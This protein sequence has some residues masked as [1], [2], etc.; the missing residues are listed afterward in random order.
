PAIVR[1]EAL[2]PVTMWAPRRRAG[3]SSP[4]SGSSVDGGEQDADP[5]EESTEEPVD[6]ALPARAA[7]QPPQP[8]GRGRE[9]E[10]HD[11]H[12]D[13]DDRHPEHDVLRQQRP[14]RPDELRDEREEEDDRLRV[15]EVDEEPAPDHGPPRLRAVRDGLA[16][17]AARA[18]PP[19]PDPE[20]DEVGGAAIPDDVE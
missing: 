7:G 12:V 3:S 2:R 13:H 10:P 20:V 8:R 6:G 4:T 9:E 18:R 1:P 15:R 19:L 16:V 5:D 14:V 11:E 17:V